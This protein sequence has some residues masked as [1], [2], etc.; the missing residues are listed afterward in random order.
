MFRKTSYKDLVFAQNEFLRIVRAPNES[1]TL[2]LIYYMFKY[3]AGIET[4]LLVQLRS[5]KK[6]LK[7]MFRQTSFKD[8]VF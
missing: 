6:Y 3:S 2:I 8:L 4:T 1:L 5:Q 7:A